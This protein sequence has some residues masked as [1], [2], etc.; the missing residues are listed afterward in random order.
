MDTCQMKGKKNGISPG[1]PIAAYINL[2]LWDR[3]TILEFSLF[4]YCT[5]MSG[6]KI[7]LDKNA[8]KK[9]KG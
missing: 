7:S 9:K 3:K 4:G 8:K 1:I 2:F 6:N 5:H